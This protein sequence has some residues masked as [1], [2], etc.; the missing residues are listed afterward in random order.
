MPAKIKDITGQR[1][2]RLTALSISKDVAYDGS[3]NWLVKCDCGTILMVNGSRLRRGGV[4]SCGCYPKELHSKQLKTHGKSKTRLFSVWQQM[5][6]RCSNSKTKAYKD[7]GGR[8]IRV[9]DEWLH[10]FQAF[11]DWAIAH[12]YDENAPRG[13]CTLDR[14]DVNG[15]YEPSNCRFATVKEQQDNRRITKKYIVN[16]REYKSLRDAAKFEKIPVS[17]MYSRFYKENKRS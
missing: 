13:K 4:V 8:G 1:F 5:K 17:T 11:Y 10:N 9:C 15:N 16:G 3:R 6:S 12:G 2:G 14:I 7:Y